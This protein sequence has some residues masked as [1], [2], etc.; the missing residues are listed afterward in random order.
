MDFC[1]EKKTVEHACFI[2]LLNT[3]NVLMTDSQE[4]VEH[5]SEYM[6]YMYLCV[7]Q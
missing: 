2:K 7:F 4:V 5:A 1:K 3:K 6:I